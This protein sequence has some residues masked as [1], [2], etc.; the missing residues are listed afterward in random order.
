V[1]R[2]RPS[3]KRALLVVGERDVSWEVLTAEVLYKLSKGFD[4][5][6]VL[7][8]SHLSYPKFATPPVWVRRKWHACDDFEFQFT[9]QS[10]SHIKLLA[11]RN[12]NDST[13][14]A[15]SAVE[16]DAI[17]NSAL[18]LA[19]S[20]LGSQSPYLSHK[21]SSNLIRKSSIRRGSEALATAVSEIQRFSPDLVVIPNG[22]LP[23]QKGAQLAALRQKTKVMFYEHGIFRTDHFY[24]S[25]RQSHN[26]QGNQSHAKEARVGQDAV[27]DALDWLSKRRNPL[28]GLNQYASTW[29]EGAP[30]LLE[31]Y[32]HSAALFTSSEDESV[33]LE[34]WSGFGWRDQYEAFDFFLKNVNGSSVIR[35]HPNFLNKSFSTALMELSRIWW[36][37][38][39]HP[40]LKVVL[41]NDPINSYDLLET[42]KRVL[43]YGSTIGLEAHCMGKSVWNAGNAIYDSTF[44]IRTLKPNEEY[45][46]SHFNPW[47]VDT[48]EALVSLAKLMTLETPYRDRFQAQNK[49]YSKVPSAIRL[50]NLVRS[51]SYIYFWALMLTMVS[52][53]INRVL[54]SSFRTRLRQR[55]QCFVP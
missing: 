50:F 4:E 20:L 12:A 41:P 27:K 26:K 52:R 51:R 21:V 29:K 24:L 44:D 16:L 23:Y 6:S 5:V 7:D 19:V 10:S 22:R 30:L 8:L 33:G 45:S 38:R 25:E 39:N 42:T 54:V 48:T 36:L 3:P 28:G 2:D 31:S 49:W 53:R 37:C 13:S 35:V 47:E 34:G 46:S 15:L 55:Q 18:S 40:D 17:E 14:T 1:I 9:W 43:V 11:A 32:N